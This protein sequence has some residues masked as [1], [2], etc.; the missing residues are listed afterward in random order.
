MIFSNL[1]NTPKR[2]LIQLI[3]SK[4]SRTALA[5]KNIVLSFGLKGISIIISF[6]LVPLTINYLNVTDYGIWLTLS[7]ILTWIN[8]F[9][10]G[11]A[12][13]LRNKLTEVLAHQ[14][15]KLAR[16]YVSTTFALL[17]VIIGVFFALFIITNLFLHWDQILNTPIEERQKLN[18]LVIIVFA[19]F[20]LQ[21]VFKTV[22]IILVSAQKPAIND[23][24]NIIANLISLVVIYTLT[25]TTTA[26]LNYVACT[27]AGAPFMVFLFAYVALFW[28]K[29]SY[30]RPSFLSI[31]LQ[32][33]KSLIGL[34]LKF[35]II[36]I[37][38]CIVIYTS[39]NILLTQ[40]FGSKSVTIYNIA[41]KYFNAISMAYMIIIMPFWSA[42]TDAYVKQDFEW[43]Q[44]SLQ[45]LIAMFG[46]SLMV[47]AIMIIFSN[48]FYRF[49]V[50]SAIEIPFS[51]S[52]LV[53][54]YITLF[55]WSNTFI[56][57]I[58][59]I[60]KIQLQLLITIIIAILYIPMAI[61]L[62]HIWQINGVVLASIISLLPTSI[63]MPIQCKKIYSANA[64][65]IW[66]K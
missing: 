57:F 1:P 61:F 55:N 49:W 35:F 48:K 22:G 56:Y 39:T 60:G 47:T 17:T 44:K 46:L 9:D 40:L 29:Y 18:N 45:K 11:L 25:K 32:Y 59:G 28:G 7:S 23:L 5:Q 33:T 27:F 41:F 50:G 34:G 13:G 26:S 3:S 64:T 51:L 63:L 66:N 37:A 36:Q 31:D 10:I 54:I 16:K 62:G 6:L 30:L 42:A 8:F 2:A 14:D 24:L 58:N 20:C 19:F 21:F 65:G 43:I 53:A 4:D 15:L 38:V 12:N 52:V